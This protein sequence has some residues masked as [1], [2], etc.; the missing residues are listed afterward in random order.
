M[1]PVI[2]WV[3]GAVSALAAVRLFSAASR[4]ANADLERV[5][6]D[7][8]VAKPLEKLERDPRSGVYRPRR[9]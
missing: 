9:R 6:R 8:A 1:P 2:V 7:G 5:R 3:I 4:K